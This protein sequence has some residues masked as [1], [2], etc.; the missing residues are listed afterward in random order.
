MRKTA[1]LVLLLFSAPLVPAQTRATVNEMERLLVSLQKQDDESA[2]AR[3]SGCELSERVSFARL[4]RW[5]SMLR[6]SQSRN[7]LLALTDAS[8]FEPLPEADLPAN[9]PPDE[10]AQ[11]AILSRAT[12]Y[13]TNLRPRLPNFTATHTATRFQ[14]STR[15]EIAADERNL[16]YQQMNH[17]KLR[18]RALGPAGVKGRSLYLV[19]TETSAVTFR[20]GAEVRSPD[21]SGGKEEPLVPNGLMSFGEF[22]PILLVVNSDASHGRIEWDH[23]EK[24]QDTQLAI[25]RYLV[26]KDQSHFATYSPDPAFPGIAPK[27]HYPAYHGEIAIDPT[28]GSIL[29]ITILADS[30]PN[31]AATAAGIA[32]EYAA[33][34]IGGRTYICPVHAAAVSAREASTPTSRHP[35]QSQL[36][37]YI[38]DVSFTNYHV[39]RSDARVIPD[40]PAKP[41]P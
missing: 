31:G 14:V 26:P 41:E 4:T 40:T 12:E 6:G 11:S 9:P 20:D 15:E 10:P 18:Y 39:F 33:V 30:D 37:K 27:P 3:L 29:R 16:Q 2:A 7:A 22:G 13:V 24:G 34:P 17:A 19:G 36:R 38:N 35:A 1:I 28:D 25:F 23:W 21:S 8:A 32:V 5:Q